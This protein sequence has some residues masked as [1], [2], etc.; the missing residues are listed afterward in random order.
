MEGEELSVERRAGCLDDHCKERKKKEVN[1]AN[2]GDEG[3]ETEVTNYY[4]FFFK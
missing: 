2:G 4:L 3:G 1:Q